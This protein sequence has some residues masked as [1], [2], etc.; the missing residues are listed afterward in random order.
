MCNVLTRAGLR[1][2]QDFVLGQSLNF[3]I[4]VCSK[5]GGVYD[6]INDVSNTGIGHR[7]QAHCCPY[8]YRVRRDTWPAVAP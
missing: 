1:S 8:L 3:W 7:W 2:L 4:G 5:V 6:S